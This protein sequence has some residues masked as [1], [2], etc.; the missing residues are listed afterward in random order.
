MNMKLKNENALHQLFERNLDWK[1]G[2]LRKRK[3][4]FYF[5]QIWQVLFLTFC[6]K[7]TSLLLLL[8]RVLYATHN[9][10]DKF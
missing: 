3:K 1:P 10:S 2:Y 9:S 5:L 8:H 7:T 6:Q 4:L